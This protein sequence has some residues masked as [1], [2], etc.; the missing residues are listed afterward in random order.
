M[1]YYESAEGVTITRE[2]AFQELEAHGH[3]LD[4][5]GLREFFREC[6]NAPRYNAQRVLAFLGH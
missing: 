3:P 2:R 6:G 5:R 1:T 4:F